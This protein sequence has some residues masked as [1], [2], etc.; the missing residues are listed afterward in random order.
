MFK[1]IPVSRIYFN[2]VRG[3]KNPSAKSIPNLNR[4]KKN[5]TV[6]LAVTEFWQTPE[7]RNEILSVC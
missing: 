4:S 7:R 5:R 2:F 1:I 6:G 3:Q